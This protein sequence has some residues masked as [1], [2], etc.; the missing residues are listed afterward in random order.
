MRGNR[1]ERDCVVNVE[2]PIYDVDSETATNLRKELRNHG[3]NV[4]GV[5]EILR[6]KWKD[7]LREFILKSTQRSGRSV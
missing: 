2:I 4:S 7:P 6:Q 3:L 5:A 1:L